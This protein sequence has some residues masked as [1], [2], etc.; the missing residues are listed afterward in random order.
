VWLLLLR[1]SHYE[2]A[3]GLDL[4]TVASVEDAELEEIKSSEL[5]TVK[6][7]ARALR[8]EWL[9]QKPEWL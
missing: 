2:L 5:L 1:F 8:T 9:E 3:A 7:R 6:A 4:E